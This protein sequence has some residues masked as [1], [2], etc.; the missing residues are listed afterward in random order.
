[1][2]WPTTG[3]AN[4]KNATVHKGGAAEVLARYGIDA[5]PALADYGAALPRRIEPSHGH[6]GQ[7]EAMGPV[8][9]PVVPAP[10]EEN[11]LNTQKAS[12][13]ILADMPFQM[14][15]ELR[16][17]LMLPSREAIWFTRESGDVALPAGIGSTADVIT[18]TMD[19][20]QTGALEFYGTAVIPALGSTDVTWS[21]LNSTTGGHPFLTNQVLPTNTMMFP[22]KFRQELIQSRTVTL[23]ATNQVAGAM[24]VRAVLIGWEEYMSS[25][26]HFGSSSAAGIG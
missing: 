12:R 17:Q 23:R 19:E 8:A 25:E 2:G 18:L 20:N 11:E 26:K 22:R 21:L 6:A 24:I 9:M 13:S 7:G 10:R 15:M 16:R 3:H 14:I 4:E 1:M 5:P